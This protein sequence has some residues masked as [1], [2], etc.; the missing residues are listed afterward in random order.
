MTAVAILKL[1]KA[2]F[3]DQQV[4]A[5]AEFSEAGTATKSDIAGLERKLD[6]ARS[7]LELAIEKVR[8]DL[9]PRIAEGKAETIRW[10]VGVG[11]AQVAMILAVLRLF[12]SVHP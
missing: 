2:G 11:F 8:H 10:V 4:E 6:T 12:P 3:T 5:L 1:Q 9:E 7:D